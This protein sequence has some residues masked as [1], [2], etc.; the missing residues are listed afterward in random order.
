MNEKEFYK[1]AKQNRDKG[2]SV[3]QTIQDI[4]QERLPR[5][6]AWYWLGKWTD[7]DLYDYG[8][9]LDLGWFTKKEMGEKK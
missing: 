3:R 2:I 7:R 4:G 1:I 5:K 6:R 9:S 8:V